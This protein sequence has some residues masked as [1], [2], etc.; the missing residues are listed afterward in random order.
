M[1]IAIGVTFEGGGTG[2]I[3]ATAALSNVVATIMITRKNRTMLT[4]FM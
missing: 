3:P 2:G 4:E 1:L